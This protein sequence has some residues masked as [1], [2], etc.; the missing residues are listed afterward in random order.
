M[1]TEEESQESLRGLANMWNLKLAIDQRSALLSLL[2]PFVGV[3][4]P[5]PTFA[6]VILPSTVLGRSG[7]PM[8]HR[9]NPCRTPYFRRRS[10][11]GR[12]GDLEL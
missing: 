6:Q 5:C 11:A 8:K 2:G 4:P 1:I 3:R 10:S 7:V 9:T 12:S